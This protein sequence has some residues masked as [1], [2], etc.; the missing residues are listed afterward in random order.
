MN[1]QPRPNKALGQHWLSDIGSLKAIC[2]AANLSLSDTV[3][4][5][6]PGS[7]T[8]TKLLVKQTREVVAV[9]LDPDLA[10]RLLQ[11]VPATN[12][13]VI[14]QDI[15]RFDFAAMPTN[16]K[17]VANIPYYLSS[18]LIRVISESANPPQLAVLL[19]Q[20]E[21][22]ERLAAKPGDMSLLGVSAQFYWEISLGQVVDA[23]LFT[24]PPKVSSQ[25]V[26]L[27]LRKPELFPEVNPR[28]YFRVV[29]AGFAGRRK[30]LLNSLS[31]GLLM[32]KEVVGGLLQTVGI[33]HNVRAQE[34]SLAEWHLLYLAVQDYSP[35][36]T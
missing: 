7:G 34:L 13:N 23:S 4:E 15:L 35:A 8:L 27:K 19:L 30:T 11:I 6:G 24:P 17:I 28:A 12:L 36:K 2:R 29:K 21:V 14:H 9:E 25:I 31:S 16:Y 3:L 1:E 18:N 22:A 20:K 32:P 26:S 10:V 33:D 5:I